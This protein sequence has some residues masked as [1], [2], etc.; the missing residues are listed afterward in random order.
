M[1][2]FGRF[3][4]LLDL[5]MVAFDTNNYSVHDAPMDKV[6]LMETSETV[7][8]CPSCG[9][10]NP[11]DAEHCESCGA[12]LAAKEKA[13]ERVFERDSSRF[14]LE[15]VVFIATSGVWSAL[16]LALLKLFN[17]VQID[18]GGLATAVY[19]TPLVLATFYLM[20]YIVSKLLLAAP[21][22]SLYASYREGESIPFWFEKSFSWERFGMEFVYLFGI[23]I[24][25]ALIVLLGNH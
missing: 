1:A 14:L 13:S 10:Q 20:S 4:L 5:N 3:H 16:V 24:F 7:I 15:R 8:T 9:K 25:I 11:A 17:R 19:M 23:L 2:R 21:V 6:E 18:S 22:G 12:E